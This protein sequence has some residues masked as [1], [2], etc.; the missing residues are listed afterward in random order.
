ML[1]YYNEFNYEKNFKDNYKL[2]F[3]PRYILSLF[4]CMFTLMLALE[5]HADFPTYLGAFKDWKVFSFKENEQ[6]ACYAISDP[7]AV[8][9]STSRT[10]SHIYISHRP[11]LHN[12]NEVSFLIGHNLKKDTGVEVFIDNVPFPLVV[13]GNKAWTKNEAEDEKLVDALL[14]GSKL[15]LKATL[16]SGAALTQT[17]SLRGSSAAH[18]LLNKKCPVLP[19]DT[20]AS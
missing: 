1:S 19:H 7:T 14:K 12:F 10:N 18:G 3:T 2:M 20:K 17:Y 8:T 13:K 15:I 4:L 11:A 5:S 9:G 16:R 6:L